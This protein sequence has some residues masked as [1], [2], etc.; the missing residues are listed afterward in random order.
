M[1]ER[2]QN[3]NQREQNNDRALGQ[4]RDPEGKVLIEEA[5]PEALV[6][7]GIS[8]YAQ[9][10]LSRPRKLSSLLEKALFAVNFTCGVYQEVDQRGVE[11]VTGCK[12]RFG[13]NKIDFSLRNVV[14][15]VDHAGWQCQFADETEP[16]MV[17]FSLAVTQEL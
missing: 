15:Q 9:I 11:T 13:A 12:H 14:R 5:P 10:D 3:G 1:E 4:C 7:I 2:K 17:G 6:L 8:R 16:S